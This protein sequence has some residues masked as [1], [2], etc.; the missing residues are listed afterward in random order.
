MM[1]ASATIRRRRDAANIVKVCHGAHHGQD[2][3]VIHFVIDG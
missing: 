3:D 2:A 1:R